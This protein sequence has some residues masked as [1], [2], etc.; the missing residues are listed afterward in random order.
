ML[1]KEYPK[2]STQKG[3]F[4]LLRADRGG[5]RR[6]L[7]PI[8]SRYGI[9]YLKNAVSSHAIIYVR[10]IQSDTSNPPSDSFGMTQVCKSKCMNCLKDI[11]VQNMKSHVE[12]C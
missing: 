8:P 2:L 1:Q 6:P 3:A 11:L 12:D 10:P 4:E 9:S 5:A 7:I